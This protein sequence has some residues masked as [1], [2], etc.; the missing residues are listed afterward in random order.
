MLHG[1]EPLLTWSLVNQVPAVSARRDG[2][3]PC[4]PDGEPKTTFILSPHGKNRMK[5]KQKQL[6]L[7]QVDERIEQQSGSVSAAATGIEN[8]SEGVKNSGPETELETP[9]PRVSTRSKARKSEGEPLPD[10][11]S[12][13]K[14]KSSGLK[15][16]RSDKAV[17]EEDTAHA[18]R[19]GSPPK[20]KPTL[21]RLKKKV[22]H[23][24]TPF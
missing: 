7:T 20:L 13:K 19:E 8:V 3:S 17:Q 5:A 2:P 18:G 14:A 1:L 21:K 16:S 15:E 12:S 9:A 11:P 24:V 4:T 23:R 10:A 6:M 22:N